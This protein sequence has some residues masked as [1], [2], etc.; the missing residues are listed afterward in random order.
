MLREEVLE[1]QRVSVLAAP[2]VLW[3]MSSPTL[4]IEKDFL[5][6]VIVKPKK[7]VNILEV[8]MLLGTALGGRGVSSFKA[9]KHKDGWLPACG[10]FLSLAF[11]LQ[12]CLDLAILTVLG[13][14]IDL[15]VW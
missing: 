5:A 7:M 13:L 1:R 10:L 15:L 8:L 12:G 3:Y 14:T 6:I 4:Q 9:E 11:L 2:S